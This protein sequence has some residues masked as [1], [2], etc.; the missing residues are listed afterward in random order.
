[1][2]TEGRPGH[3]PLLLARP[4]RKN[5]LSTPSPPFV[6]SPS[7]FPHTLAL[8]ARAGAMRAY[9][10]ADEHFTVHRATDFS[11]FEIYTVSEMCGC[12]CGCGCGGE[13][14]GGMAV[15][16]K[17]EI[18][19]QVGSQQLPLSQQHP[20]PSPST[21]SV[22]SPIPSAPHPPYRLL[23]RIIRWSPASNTTS[24]KSGGGEGGGE[25]PPVRGC[26]RMPAAC[27]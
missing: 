25:W 12:G 27:R 5:P 23:P 16:I 14:E 20:N 3:T 13:R 9:R 1:M 8:L 2:A 22:H 6:L 26:T 7:P 17:F 24:S 21:H 15:G 4:K 18:L 10:S 19:V 11:G